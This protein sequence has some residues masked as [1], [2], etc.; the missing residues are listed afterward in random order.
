MECL[1]EINDFYFRFG[2]AHRAG[3]LERLMRPRTRCPEMRRLI[4]AA[5]SIENEAGQLGGHGGDGEAGLQH[6]HDPP[7]QDVE[8]DRGVPAPL[9]G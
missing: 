6:G 5:R 4:S 2:N 7:R 8:P 9:D 3:S 1:V